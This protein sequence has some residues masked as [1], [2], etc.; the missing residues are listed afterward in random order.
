MMTDDFA[1]LILT[2]KRP[3]RQYTIDALRRSGYTGKIYLVVDDQDPTLPEYVRRY[4]DMVVVFDKREAWALTDDADNT[5]EMKG[6][7]YARNMCWSIAKKLGLKFFIELDDDYKMF[8]FR[9]DSLLNYK[10]IMINK[11]LDN[12]IIAMVRWMQD[13]NAITCIAMSQG[14]DHIGGGES[15]YNKLGPVCRR[16]V[17]NTFIC[18]VDRP[19]SFYGRINEDATAYVTLGR[20]GHVF[21]TPL[22]I[23]MDQIE[24]QSNP[25]GLTEI[26]LDSGTYYKSFLSVMWEPSCV[27]V[28]AMGSPEHGQAAHYRLH[29]WIDW[30]R[31]VPC[32]VR[33]SLRKPDDEVSDVE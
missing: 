23:Q 31:A 10:S 20:R 15:S 12:V 28:A 26:Y 7:V 13:C 18:S 33:E 25:G 29:H 22:Q 24:T 19:F 16:K 27:R 6:V 1:A 4:G 3:D 5:G 17:M 2:H 14:G 9:F 8:R 11:T 32:I 30:K 21:M